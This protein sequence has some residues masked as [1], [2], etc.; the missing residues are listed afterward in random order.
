[1][2]SVGTSVPPWAVMRVGPDL[3][4]AHDT[5]NPLSSG[6]SRSAVSFDDIP[7]QWEVYAT[8]AGRSS[9][10]FH[11]G[12]RRRHGASLPNVPWLRAGGWRPPDLQ[13]SGASDAS[14]KVAQGC[15]FLPSH[16]VRAS[17]ARTP[18]SAAVHMSLATQPLSVNLALVSNPWTPWTPVGRI[19][20]SA[21][22]ASL[23]STA[24]P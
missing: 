12:A 8:S 10:M 19:R 7:I 20:S 3:I 23:S 1:M 22:A 14:R 15:Q 5:R 6:M 4:H 21:A 11:H 13:S 24:S 17:H 9:G 16:A 18:N 2:V